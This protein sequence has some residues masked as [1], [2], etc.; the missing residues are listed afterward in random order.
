MFYL[1][2]VIPVRVS[3]L[4]ISGKF[5]WQVYKQDSV[6]KPNSLHQG[7]RDEAS[8]QNFKIKILIVVSIE[9]ASIF[10]INVLDKT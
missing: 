4:Q 3:M 5:N 9:K 8:A 10:S 6:E 2:S 1:K 7:W